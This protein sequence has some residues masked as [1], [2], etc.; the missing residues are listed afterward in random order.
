MRQF[1]KFK[2]DCALFSTNN[3]MIS[4]SSLSMSHLHRKAQDLQ[5]L[6][7]PTYRSFYHAL[8]L[9]RSRNVDA[10]AVFRVVGAESSRLCSV[11]ESG[12]PFL[13]MLHPEHNGVSLHL[14]LWR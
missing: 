1:K 4:L 7:G 3:M 11:R 13:A 12:Q 9:L 10:A 2:V 8:L 5:L 14:N 6:A